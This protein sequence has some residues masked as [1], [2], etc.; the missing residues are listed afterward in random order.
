M[1]TKQAHWREGTPLIQIAFCGCENHSASAISSSPARPAFC[2][3]WICLVTRMDNSEHAFDVRIENAFDF[4]SPEYAEL[5][6][7]SAATAFQHPIWLD[8]L[9]SKLVPKVGAKPLIV[10]VRDRASGT[11]A[12]VLPLLRVR[13]GPIRT[14]E[15]ADLRVSDYLAAVCTEEV[16][17]DLLRDQNACRQIRRVV[18]PF[19]LLRMPKLP[20][21]RLPIENLLAAPRRISM[22]TNAYSAVL[23]APFAEWRANALNRSYQ[24]ELA[25]KSRQLHKKGTLDFSCCDDGVSIAAAM[26]VMRKLRGP[27][28]QAQVDGDLLQRPGVGVATPQQF[29]QAGVFILLGCV[30]QCG[31]NARRPMVGAV[32]LLSNR[33]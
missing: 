27:R 15:F 6:N 26:D 21:G 2:N 29:A 12:M 20:D 31:D 23:V 3:Y 11:L 8:G 32:W 33:G 19:D 30:T 25:K 24:K 18:G 10:V 14:V 9:Y 13:R 28:F 7:R 16:F 1:V 5:F 4:L 17:S 22:D